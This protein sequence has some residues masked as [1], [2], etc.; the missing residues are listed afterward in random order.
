MAARQLGV[1][2]RRDAFF[3]GNARDAEDDA[4]RLR[5]LETENT[6]RGSRRQ[7]AGDSREL[8]LLCTKHPRQVAFFGFRKDLN[9]VERSLRIA[10]RYVLTVS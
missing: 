6:S 4:R 8:V 9:D 1:H 5:L 3:P 2:Y 10:V 7:T